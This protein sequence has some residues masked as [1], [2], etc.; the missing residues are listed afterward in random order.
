MAEAQAGAMPLIWEHLMRQGVPSKP[1]LSEVQLMV[2]W[3]LEEDLI[4]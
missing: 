4:L 3:G 2:A 1:Y